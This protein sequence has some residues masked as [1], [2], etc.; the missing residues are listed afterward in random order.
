MTDT[1]SISP[2]DVT[3]GLASHPELDLIRVAALA[4]NAAATS[5]EASGAT[6]AA[7]C[8]ALG[9]PLGVVWTL[10]ARTDHLVPGV[11][12]AAG[13]TAMVVRDALRP[14][15]RAEAG[16][17]GTL[18]ATAAP[19]I[20][21]KRTPDGTTIDRVASRHG[22]A[23][24]AAFGIMANGRVAAVL[25]FFS[26]DGRMPER[27]FLATM[28][29]VCRQLAR[30]VEREEAHHADPGVP[31][32]AL[33]GREAA[34]AAVDRDGTIAAWN[35]Q[36][37]R[38]FGWSAT[39]VVGTRMLTSTLV[40]P[41][42]REAPG[43]H[44]FHW[45]GRRGGATQPGTWYRLILQHRDGAEVPVMTTS[46]QSAVDRS[47]TCV[48]MRPVDPAT[49]TVT[50]TVVADMDPV[51]G[52]ASRTAFLQ[53][54]QDALATTARD[55]I[56]GSVDVELLD[57]DAAESGLA[58]EEAVT[59]AVARRLADITGDPRTV[60]RMSPG[61]FLVMSRVDRS[62]GA[63]ATAFA[64]Q[65][66]DSF[67]RDLSDLGRLPLA[68]EVAVGVVAANQLA[69]PTSDRLVAAARRARRSAT[70]T[71]R[72]GVY[73][74][75]E[76]LAAATRSRVRT[77]LRTA[78][79][80]R[81]LEVHYHPQVDLATGR[82][83]GAEALV[84]WRHPVRGLVAPSL[85]IRE[86]EHAGLIGPLGQVVLDA[87]LHDA[88]SWQARSATPLSIAVN[89]SPAQLDDPGFTTRVLKA[90]AAAG[91][92]PSRLVLEITETTVSQDTT[93]SID[94]LQQLRAAGIRIAIDDFGSGYS[95][96]GRL[97]AFAFD[98]IKLD[99]ILLQPVT[100]LDDPVPLLQAAADM[101]RSLDM[102]VVAEGVETPEQLAAALR[103]GCHQAQGHL[104][105]T[106]LPPDA[107]M[108][109]LANPAQ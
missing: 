52:V 35:A 36:A 42:L 98:Q 41:V 33:R 31:T 26:Q 66:R 62:T 21:F 47:R 18:T 102:D 63:D 3:R 29:T 5:M 77:D 11:V 86:A 34:L 92:E 75:H 30:V 104:F 20:L 79:D 16:V 10:E 14:V 89:L 49:G 70:G 55:T 65:I 64:R 106:A 7:V 91:L 96:L 68:V 87:A 12:H 61:E 60:A 22:L 1:K 48:L 85:F 97:Q 38:L 39:E 73:E 19:G 45:L 109:M 56:V 51:T 57:D 71:R 50:D 78:I 8:D 17:A 82:L 105:A 108:R 99:R 37:E 83:C 101:A 53:R 27:P 43:G 72:V 93:V 24:G 58:V 76:D 32:T 40:P 94:R 69:S 44:V 81:Q 28:E 74:S 88:V 80:G 6:T 107:F 54:L 9:W 90:V 84:R 2:G 25:E 100:R 15:P 103:V 46:W 13:S 59:A 95:S 67:D 23:M 4:S